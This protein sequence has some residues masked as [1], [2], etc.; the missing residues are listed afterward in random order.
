MNDAQFKQVTKEAFYA[1][2]GPR[3]VVVSCEHSR[4]K[5][6]CVSTF[7]TRS[8]QRVGKVTAPYQ[9]EKQYFLPTSA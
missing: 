1:Y 2:I 6:E 5:G 3:D 7:E 8:R 9:G 4:E